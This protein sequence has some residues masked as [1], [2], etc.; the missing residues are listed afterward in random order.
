MGK[1]IIFCRIQ[2]KF[3]FWLYKKR[4]HT[5][6]KC[7]TKKPLTNLYEM[8]SKRCRGQDKVSHILRG[9]Y[10]QFC[11]VW[12]VLNVVFRHFEVRLMSFT[13]P[14]ICRQKVLQYWSLLNWHNLQLRC[15]CVA[16]PVKWFFDIISSCFA[17]FKNVVHSWEPG[18]TPS[19]SASHQAPNY[20][21]CS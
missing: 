17:K 5:S 9:D 21:Q 7:T 2:L 20:V 6:R 15:G 12:F 14:L 18:E 16:F 3:R 4:W 10:T 8:N 11:Y 19:Y 1:F 13:I